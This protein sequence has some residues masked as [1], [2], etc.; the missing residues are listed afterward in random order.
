MDKRFVRKIEHLKDQ[1]IIWY[2]EHF[3]SQQEIAII[4]SV[5]VPT[6]N[7]LLKKYR[8]KIRGGGSRKFGQRQKAEETLAALRAMKET[9]VNVEVDQPNT[10]SSG[11]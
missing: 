1:I 11:T 3:L 9:N 10:V 2:K 6:V 7:R 4:C 5:S 8:V